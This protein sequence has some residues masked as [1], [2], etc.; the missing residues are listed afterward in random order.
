MTR[1]AALIG[2]SAVV[3][4]AAAALGLRL[5]FEAEQVTLVWPATGVA[6][7]ALL[8]L[9]RE[10][11]P[12][13]AIGAFAANLAANEPVLTAAGIAVGNTLEATLGAWAL[14]R[15]GVAPSLHRLR[16]VLALLVCAAL[17]STLVSATIGVLCLCA[18]G[19][20]PWSAAHSLL[21]TWWIGDAISD[22]VVAPVI[23]VWADALRRGV[24]RRRLLE[25]VALLALT[26]LIGLGVLA[27]G[28]MGPPEYPLHYL[29]FPA[30]VWAALRM[31]LVGA[32]AVTVLVWM[33]A[34]V[35]TLRGLGPFSLATPHESLV[36]L[37][38][39]MAVVA[40][41]GLLLG[42]AIAERDAAERRR[43]ADFRTLELS[44]HRL[45]LALE[46]GRMGVW[47]WDVLPQGGFGGAFETFLA[48]VHPEDRA[49]VETTIRGAFD[50]GARY[51]VEFRGLGPDGSV[52]WLAA[53]GT[54][55]R[56]VAGRPVRVVG[57]GV[58]VTERRRLEETLRERAEQLVDADRR[59][60]EFLAML[61]HEL[62][63]P[64]APLKMSL[65]LLDIGVGDR[66]RF[67][68]MAD[69]QV[70]HLVRLVDDL[71]DVSRITR[72]KITLRREPVLLSAIVE[73]AVEQSRPLVD[74]RGHTLTVSLPREEIRLDADLVRLV[75][76][77]ANLLSN[78]AKYTPP[79]GS[80]W[81]TAE[82]LGDEVVLR[83]RDTGLGMAPELQSCVFE[84]FVQGDSS[85]DRT[86]GGLGI[87]LTLVRALVE[88]HG[89]RVSATSPGVGLGSEFVVRL[90]T[91]PGA[92]PDAPPPG[93]RTTPAGRKLRVLVVEDNQDAAESLRVLL[94][95]WGH[96][97]RVAYDG[98]AALRLAE[99]GAP[100]VILSDL[101]L[102]G[103]DG[104]ELARQLRARPGFGRVVLVALSGYGRDE[105]RRL[106]AEAGFDHHLVKPPDLDALLQLMGNVAAAPIRPRTLH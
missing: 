36:M 60:D 61:A 13:I 90:P 94:E 63:N 102:P 24:D 105:D 3:Y 50:S 69:R 55:L 56:D 18:S 9:G 84:L 10:V 54:V 6:L 83:V 91:L 1:R 87:G 53:R 101:G 79:S 81:V 100:D 8:L 11:W 68:E 7:A 40:C 46:T 29:L 103:M 51:E 47:D 57:I 72:G 96:E 64:L 52:H 75:Q 44:E 88:L 30:V 22:V 82:R 35:G 48:R 31:R 45:R 33:L 20:H 97:V 26:V 27:G 19:L 104:Y 62:R 66:D 38:L 85:I 5:A 80:I 14:V 93:E 65:E 2:V 39:F 77:V 76:V 49:R 86:R 95:L 21:L 42:A 25:G 74:A 41:T 34:I 89:G 106:S 67:L 28:A 4:F 37:Q 73:R 43:S 32:T 15:L 58:D 70:R 17:A 78:A 98:L 16:D 12:G 99:A 71:L 23:L 92:A 59:K